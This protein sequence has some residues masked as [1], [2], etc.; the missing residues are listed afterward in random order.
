M[1][2]GSSTLAVVF[3]YGL[4]LVSFSFPR[5][6]LLRMLEGMRPRLAEALGRQAPSPE[7]MLAR[8]LLPLEDSLGGRSEDE[9][10]YLEVYAAAWRRAG[11]E[12]PPGLVWELLDREQRC[13]D[14]SV[15]LAPGA[16]AVLGRLRELGVRS[17]VCSN[18]PFPPALMR[19]QV[20]ENGIGPLAD[21]VVFSSEVGRRK[22]APEIFHAVLRQ[23]DVA[24]AR[25]LHVGDRV[26]E[27]Y[28]GP[29]RLGMQA[30]LCRALAREPLPDGLPVVAGLAEVEHLL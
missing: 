3:D 30:V 5:A 4:T 14:R 25:A 12:L 24:P 10:D 13:W 19:R 9:V 26:R 11:L 8:V 28:E 18:A 17:G 20:A 16:L 27:D 22:P 1:P 15:E 21:A 29:R 6:A 2:S 23:L 7:E